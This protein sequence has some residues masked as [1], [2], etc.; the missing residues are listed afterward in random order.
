ME[1]RRFLRFNVDLKVEAKNPDS[2]STWGVLTD[3]SRE[4]LRVI[5]D[6]FKSAVASQT[7]LMIQ[8][9][10]SENYIPM[11]AEAVWKTPA[12]GN[13]WQVGF[14]LKEFSPEAK[15]NILEYGYRKWLKEN[16][17]KTAF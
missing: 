2:E 16:N 9:P 17:F 3:F 6:D 14:K 4:G 13:K 8:T 15:A 10:D 11:S 7:E 12:E 1:K 5:F